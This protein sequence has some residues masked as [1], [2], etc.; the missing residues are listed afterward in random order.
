MP[1]TTVGFSSLEYYFGM[2]W[3]G[4]Y[5]RIRGTEGQLVNGEESAIL[6]WGYGVVEDPGTPGEPAAPGGAPT[7]P[8][9][10]NP[11][12]IVRPTAKTNF[13]VGVLTINESHGIPESAMITNKDRGIAPGTPADIFTWGDIVVPIEKSITIPI[14]VTYGESVSMRCIPTDEHEAGVFANVDDDNHILIPNS[15]WLRILKQPTDTELG[16]GVLNLGR[17]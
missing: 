15:R 7:P 17:F 14:R 9:A 1:Q 8:V 2:V 4:T 16:A 10:G 12:K 5:G 3:S 6:K 11:R 13:F